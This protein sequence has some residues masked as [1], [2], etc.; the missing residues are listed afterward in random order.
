MTE[1]EAGRDRVTAKFGS[2]GRAIERKRER[3]RYGGNERKDESTKTASP[4]LTQIIH[5][6]LTDTLMIR[7]ANRMHADT[8]ASA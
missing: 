4:P 5:F 3:G 2:S 1:G 7:I 8:P 6:R